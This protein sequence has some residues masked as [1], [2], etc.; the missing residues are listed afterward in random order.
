MESFLTIVFVQWKCNRS[1][2][3]KT[4]KMCWLRCRCL[5]C[6]VYYWL[7]VNLR[8][9]NQVKSEAISECVHVS[10]SHSLDNRIPKIYSNEIQLITK[11]IILNGFQ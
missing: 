5:Y 4:P 1:T 9:E 2:R 11:T 7:K 6:L 8:L 3:T 10:I